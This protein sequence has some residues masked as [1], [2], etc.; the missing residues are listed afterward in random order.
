M[1]L[2]LKIV[3]TD[4]SK[5]EFTGQKTVTKTRRIIIV[6]LNARQK[7]SLIHICNVLQYCVVQHNGWFNDGLHHNTLKTK[8]LWRYKWG[9]T[10]F[11]SQPV[12]HLINTLWLN[13][14]RFVELWTDNGM[15]IVRKARS[16]NMENWPRGQ[17]TVSYE[18]SREVRDVPQPISEQVYDHAGDALS[19]VWYTEAVD[20]SQL[21][22][23]L[24]PELQLLVQ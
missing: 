6:L 15:W 23:S 24:Q 3:Q 21:E 12:Q 8:W 4:Q 14:T 9:Q 5:P 1:P 7:L 16:W 17:R 10:M 13:R 22:T 11:F 2:D 18:I 20:A 19:V